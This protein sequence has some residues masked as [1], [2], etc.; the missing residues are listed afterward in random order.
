[1]PGSRTDSEYGYPWRMGTG[2][3]HEPVENKGRSES[4]GPAAL[5]LGL[6]LGM[7]GILAGTLL[8]V[9]PPLA[10]LALKMGVERGLSPK[11]NG[12]VSFVLFVLIVGW[13]VGVTL[14]RPS[15]PGEQTGWFRRYVL[16][17]RKL[18]RRG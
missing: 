9:F 1:M 15:R 8:I 12:V 5:V 4:R 6:F 2:D 7:A 14:G 3:S 13:V 18:R 11:A 17:A 10:L 16:L